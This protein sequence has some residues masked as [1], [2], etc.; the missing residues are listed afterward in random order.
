MS[1]LAFEVCPVYLDDVI[2]ISTT[3]DEHFRR[4][5]AVLSKLRDAG[6]KLKPSK[7]RLLQK[8][9][10]F[11]GHIVS[12][13]GV[14]T[15]PEKVR[16]VAD[17]PAPTTLR[18]VRSFVELCSYYRRFDEGFARISAPL[19]DTTKKGRTFCWTSE[20]QEAFEQ[21]KSALTSALFLDTD[22]AQTS[23]GAVLSQRQQGVERVVA[24]ANGNCQS[25]KSTT[26]LRARNYCRW[27]TSGFCLELL[28]LLS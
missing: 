17:W 12:E 6:L 7:Y 13:N 19:H 5:S 4:L 11:L 24:Y 10:A 23:I 2:V 8:H 26:V 25:A 20:C 3:I 27:S 16:A 18:E 14:S 22:A 15:D 28:F 9:V 21:L 1:E